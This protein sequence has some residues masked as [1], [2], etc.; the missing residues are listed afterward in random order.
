MRIL[1]IHLSSDIKLIIISHIYLGIPA[2]HQFPDGHRGGMIRVWETDDNNEAL[3]DG[4]DSNDTCSYLPI[5]PLLAAPTP[6]PSHLD[7]TLMWPQQWG[8]E[9]NVTST[10]CETWP[11]LLPLPCPHIWMQWWHDAV[12]PVTTPALPSSPL[13]HLARHSSDANMMPTQPWW[14]ARHDQW[15]WYDNG[16]ND[17]CS[18]LTLEIYYLSE[19][20]VPTRC[21]GNS[22]GMNQWGRILTW[23]LILLQVDWGAITPLY[24]FESLVFQVI[25]TQLIYIQS[26]VCMSGW[27]YQ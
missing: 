10:T 2:P 9:A 7:M 24:E 5:S 26:I 16:D 23:C 19:L 4:H 18:L 12:S 1:Y 15:Q 3:G 22:K 27:S 25:R 21:R 14:L 13:L 17:M 6:S 8:L 20:L 11:R